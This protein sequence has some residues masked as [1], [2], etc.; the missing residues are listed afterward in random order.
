MIEKFLIWSQNRLPESVGSVLAVKMRSLHANLVSNGTNGKSARAAMLIFVIRVASAALAIILQVMLARWIGP[1]QYGIFVLVWVSVGILGI[2]TCFGLN[3]S[4]IRFISEYQTKHD[5]QRLRGILLIAPVIATVSSIL[6]AIMAYFLLLWFGD[7]IENIYI[8]PFYLALVC[9]PFFAIE[10][11]QEGIARS[12]EMPLIAIGPAFIIRPLAILGVMTLAYITGFPPTA[13][14][15]ISSAVIASFGT[16]I[17]QSFL[18]WKR[19]FALNKIDFASDNLQS[20]RQK[21]NES[22]TKY[23]FQIRLWL[24]VSMPIFLAGGFYNLLTNVDVLLIGYFLSPESIAIYFAAAKSLAVVNF[25]HYAMRNS[26]AHHFT[27]FFAN[28]DMAGLREYAIKITQLTFWPTLLLAIFMVVLGKYVLMLFGAQFADGQHLLAILAVGIV[29]RASIGPAESLLSMTGNQ[30]YS[31]MVFAA[32]LACNLGLNLVLIPI[33]GVTGAA[34][35]ISAA[36]IFETVAFYAA[37]HRKLGV[38]IFVFS[39]D[40]KIIRERLVA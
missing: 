11:I 22:S 9:V 35:A 29:A 5:H 32:A 39:T 16:T 18:L 40:K 25:V 23:R 30:K 17:W 20:N 19:V 36:I 4:V 8:M 1:A 7:H 38:R 33:F 2:L 6:I 12:Y 27:R 15:A 37:I 26:S 21:S 14:T 3:N 10:G 13:L 31:M 28:N 34:I 24:S